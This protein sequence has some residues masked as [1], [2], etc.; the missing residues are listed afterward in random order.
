MV[1]S[2]LMTE[3]FLTIKSNYVVAIPTFGDWLRNF[4]PALQSMRSEAKTTCTR[5]FSRALSVSPPSEQ[6]YS[7]L[8]RFFYSDEGRP[9]VVRLTFDSCQLVR[10]HFPTESFLRA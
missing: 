1:I 6:K 4:V 5:D 7:I 2:I 10:V 9:L 8:I 3:H